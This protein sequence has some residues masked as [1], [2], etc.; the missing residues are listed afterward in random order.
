M[1]TEDILVEVRNIVR[2]HLPDTKLVLFGSWAKGNALPESD[3]DIGILDTGKI[4]FP[5]YT[6]MRAEIDAI[7]TLRKIDLVDLNNVDENFRQSALK[8]SKAL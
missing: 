6:Q 2:R 4:P 7:P 5:L 8:H 1:N 3:L